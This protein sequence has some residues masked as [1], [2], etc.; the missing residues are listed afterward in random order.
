MSTQLAETPQASTR[1]NTS[2]VPARLDRLGWS[3]FHARLVIALGVA[4]V[5]DGLEIT[6]ASNVTNIISKPSALGLSSGSVAFSV[7]TIYLLGEVGGALFFGWLS[8]K[9][10][11]KN[12]FMITLAVYL[13]GG[14][15]TACTAGK[16]YGWVLWLDASRF[17]RGM[18][19]C[20]GYAPAAPPLAGR[21]P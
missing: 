20:G 9:W 10:G 2:L 12:L 19:I 7:G 11:R 16:G 21:H 14:L 15:L 6:I 17:I 8:D 4:W 1:P 18:G 13:A 5:L 3:R